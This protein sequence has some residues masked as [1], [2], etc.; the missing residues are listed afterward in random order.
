PAPDRTPT[1]VVGSDGGTGPICVPRALGGECLDITGAMT[2]YGPQATVNDLARFSVALPT[3][4]NQAI[5]ELQGVVPWQSRAFFS[6]PLT[7]ELFD[8]CPGVD[9]NV[10][11]PDADDDGV[12]EDCDLCE[13]DDALGDDDANG[14]CDLYGAFA[15]LW[16]G[17][18]TEGFPFRAILDL[19]PD[20]GSG[21]AGTAYYPAFG[22]YGTLTRVSEGPNRWSLHETSS[23]WQEELILHYDGPSD[24]LTWEEADANGDVFGAGVAHR[25]TVEAELTGKWRGPVDQPGS[26]P[27]TYD[28]VLDLR[29]AAP[30]QSWYPTLGCGG[31]LTR[32]A[33]HGLSMEVFEDV[34]AGNC[35]DTPIVFTWEPLQDTLRYVV[36]G[37]LAVG[38]LSRQPTYGLIA[39]TWTGTVVEPTTSYTT[40]VTLSADGAVNTQV[41]TS[42]YPALGCNGTLLRRDEAG[43]TWTFIERV[44]NPARCFDGA[45]VTLTWD[46]YTNTV[47][48]TGATSIGGAP[49]GAGTLHR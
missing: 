46:P 8:A 29:G 17:T 2:L 19:Q 28:T 26:N 22:C 20:D 38:M 4:P 14:V 11:R 44:D 25:T 21:A 5:V 23:C 32:T 39:G 18:V 24:T 10:A 16:S 6:N 49:L 31:S 35:G 1:F 15:G 48:Y 41:G 9:P 3:D 43:L 27:P 30:G 42:A 45:Y 33:S 13:G 12:S 36:P 47:R 7:I 37:D 34:P 40:T